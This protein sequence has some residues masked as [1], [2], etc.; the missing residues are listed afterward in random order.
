MFLPFIYLILF[1]CT[2]Y[3]YTVQRQSPYK[4]GTYCCYRNLQLWY[5][6]QKK[7]KHG[8][9]PDIMST[10]TQFMNLP[11]TLIYFEHLFWIQDVVSNTRR[12]KLPVS[13][14]TDYVYKIEL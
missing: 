2:W 7:K 13:F 6:L 8:D 1:F 10:A 11:V 4:N 12:L 14:L 9:Q 3:V 5:S